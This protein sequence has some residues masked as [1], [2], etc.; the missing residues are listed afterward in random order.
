MKSILSNLFI[1]TIILL[2]PAT[3]I[4]QDTTWTENDKQLLIDN[5]ERTKQEVNNETKNLTVA[6]WNFKEKKEIP[7]A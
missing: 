6:Q 2:F 3:A 4:S 7:G 5:Y 1:A